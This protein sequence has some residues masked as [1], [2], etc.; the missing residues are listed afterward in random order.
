MRMGFRIKLAML[1][2][3]G[4]QSTCKRGQFCKAFECVDNRRE[5]SIQL[6]R[7]LI[8]SSPGYQG[9][10]RNSYGHHDQFS[11]GSKG[12]QQMLNG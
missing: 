12:L 5:I 1:S 6:V 2:D 10:G 3:I 11:R 9:G 8:A 4:T 7:C